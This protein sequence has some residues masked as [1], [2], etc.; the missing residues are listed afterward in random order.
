MSGALITATDPVRTP[1]LAE[2]L[3]GLA[4]RDQS[5]GLQYGGLVGPEELHAVLQTRRNY[6]L[7]NDAPLLINSSP[8]SPFAE[9]A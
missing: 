5:H 2:D 6:G 8:R 1:V 9:Y 3:D 4:G 7:L